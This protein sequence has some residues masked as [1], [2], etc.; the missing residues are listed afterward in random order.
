MFWKNKEKEASLYYL[1]MMAD[2]DVSSSEK[3]IFKQ[4]CKDLDISSDSR[5]EITS[6]CKA[7]GKG[8]SDIF[9][10]I[11]REKIDDD[12]RKSLFGEQNKSSLAR[13]IWN[14]INLGYA[15]LVYSD[16]EK[17]I[18]NYLVDRW[19][20]DKEMVQEM[21]DTADT[22]LALTKQ[23]DWIT[24]TFSDEAEQKKRIKAANGK[25]KM[26]HNDVKLTIEELAM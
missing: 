13:I 23:K 4:L 20:L 15:D 16:R 1:Y 14:M 22:M 21:L 19:S 3:K 9:S 5:K 10:V 26:L 2:G 17:M 7:L 8:E 12:V 25:I 11:V 24:V 6:N 18:V